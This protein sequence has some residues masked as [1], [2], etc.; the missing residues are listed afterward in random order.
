[1]KEGWWCVGGEEGLESCWCFKGSL[2]C[3]RWRELPNGRGEK[4]NRGLGWELRG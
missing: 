1:M 3:R 4:G 2:K